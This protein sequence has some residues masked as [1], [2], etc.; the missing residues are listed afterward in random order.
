MKTPIPAGSIG[1]NRVVQQYL[2][3]SRELLQTNPNWLDLIYTNQR[4]NRIDYCMVPQNHP[5]ITLLL[6]QLDTANWINQQVE[7]GTEHLVIPRYRPVVMT[8]E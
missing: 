8:K 3:I 7:P 4:P 6:L 5:A 1:Q 2:Y